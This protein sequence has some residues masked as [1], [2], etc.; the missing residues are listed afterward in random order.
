MFY[1]HLAFAYI[2]SAT[3]FTLVFHRSTFAR[4]ANARVNWPTN[5]KLLFFRYPFYF[6]E[7]ISYFVSVNHYFDNLRLW[8]FVMTSVHGC[9]GVNWQVIQNNWVDLSS[10]STIYAY[11]SMHPL[12]N[13]RMCYLQGAGKYKTNRESRG[14][15]LRILMRL[16]CRLKFVRSKEWQKRSNQKGDSLPNPLISSHKL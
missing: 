10:F 16:V 8:C 2:I 3:S 13:V 11:I 4:V 5:S 9:N 14:S 6:C 15:P 7:Y 1:R 12:F